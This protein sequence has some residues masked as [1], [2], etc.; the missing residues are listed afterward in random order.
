MNILLGMQ[1][2]AH[3]LYKRGVPVLPKVIYHLQF[4]LFNS[5]VPYQVE[6]GEGT[7]AAYGGIGMVIHDRAIIGKDC[8]L[9]Q[10]MTIGGR[11]GKLEVPII[12]DRVYIGAGARILGDV[13][14]GDDV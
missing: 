6:I 11:S 12:G 8:M 9:G 1:K 2:F 13:K 3:K 10:G 7:T 14:I 4:L 5:S